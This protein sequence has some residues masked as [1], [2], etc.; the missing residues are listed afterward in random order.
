MEGGGP[1]SKRG[2]RRQ[3]ADIRGEEEVLY[4]DRGREGGKLYLGGRHLES[5]WRTVD[6][7][8]DDRQPTTRGVAKSYSTSELI[9]SSQRKMG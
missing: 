7:T 2:Q 3:G 8:R 9:L 1:G 4:P 6:E 5:G